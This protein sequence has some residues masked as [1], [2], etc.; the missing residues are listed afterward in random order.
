MPDVLAIQ[1]DKRR[2]RVVEASIGSSVRVNQSFAIDIPE[3]QKSGWLRDAL[4]QKGTS[5]KQAVVCL[6]R[7]DAILRQLELPDVPDDDLPT[8]VYFQAS[9]RS[10][11]PL[12]QLLVDYLP[13]PRRPGAVQRDVLLATVAKTTTEPIR[14]ALADAGVELQSV[15]IS[16]FCLAE[17]VLRAESAVGQPRPHSR[18]I[19]YADAG[20]LE[21][22]LLGKNEPIAAHLVR[23]T[24]DDQNRPNISKTA[25]DISRVL[26]PA[27]PWLANSPIESIWVIG[28]APEWEGLDQTL[29]D[30]WSCPVEHF[31]SHVSAKMRDLDLSRIGDAQAPYASVLGLALTRVQ[32]RSPVLDL[33][34]PRQ[35]KPKQD[36]RKLQLAVGSAAA[37]L[38]I[39]VFTSYYQMSLSSL[40]F[41]ITEAQNKLSTI[42]SSLKVDDPKRNAAVMIGEWKTHDVDQLKE[43]VE[44]HEVMQGTSRL[45]VSDYDFGQAVGDVIAKLHAIG[46]AR[47]R[48]DWQQLA[49]RLVDARSYRVKPRELTQQSRDP[50]YPNRFELDTDLVSPGKPTPPAPT[51]PTTGKD[52]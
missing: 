44:L 43:F 29:R 48:T 13:L 28:D 9:T 6:P 45:Y 31:D 47:E 20:R 41:G 23:P 39:A 17:L 46:N 8:L 1:W 18:L 49:Q 52:K 30:R 3:I 7:E 16:S 34:H 38:V 11:T 32:P 36:P 40:E 2:L 19:V 27:Q 50:D 42:N 21:A 12:D 51:G 25:A 15:T 14:A 5:A 26:V 35:P 10:T 4:R 37:M 33:L 22:V 24:L